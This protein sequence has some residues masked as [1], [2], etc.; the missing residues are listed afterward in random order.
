MN[1]LNFAGQIASLRLYADDTTTYR[2]HHDI[3]FLEISLNHDID[4]LLSWLSRNYLMVNNIKSQAMMIGD[5]A[6]DPQFIVGDSKF[7]LSNSLKIPGV[8]IDD[9]LTFA[10]HIESVIKKSLC[11]DWCP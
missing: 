10:D 3:T 11:Q 8:I 7:E 5:I 6:Y 1:D 4:I 2:S 9:K